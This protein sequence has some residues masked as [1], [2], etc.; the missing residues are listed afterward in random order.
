MICKA[1]WLQLLYMTPGKGETTGTGKATLASKPY[2]G[3]AVK[4]EHRGF[5]ERWKFSRGYQNHGG[6]L[7]KSM[8]WTTPIDILYKLLIWGDYTMWMQVLL[9]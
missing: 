5:S 4:K 3:W 6:G 1:S 8:E 2:K 7:S 9:F